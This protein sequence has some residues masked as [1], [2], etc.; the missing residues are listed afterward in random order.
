[1][2]RWPG[3]PAYTSIL[4][5]LVVLLV[6]PK[7]SGC[8]GAGSTT[9]YAQRLTVRRLEINLNA[10]CSLNPRLRSRRTLPVR[11]ESMHQTVHRA[12]VQ[13]Q[14]APSMPTK[15]R[16]SVKHKQHPPAP[17]ACQSLWVVGP[18]PVPLDLPA[19]PP[20]RWY[21]TPA[22]AE[23]KRTVAVKAAHS[24]GNRWNKVQRLLHHKTGK[25]TPALRHQGRC[26]NRV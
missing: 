20:A 19:G 4:C 5:L 6:V 10:T 1:M 17:S 14:P 25:N 13:I 9:K 26:R 3:Y 24:I 11:H 16:V 8:T 7:C 15:I 12:R 23:P 21:R 2:A 18:H 22:R